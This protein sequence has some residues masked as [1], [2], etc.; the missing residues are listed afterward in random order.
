MTAI[1]VGCCTPVR[2]IDNLQKFSKIFHHSTII[3]N[4]KWD[5]EELDS[6]IQRD[7]TDAVTIENAIQDQ[8][9]T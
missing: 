3:Q 1:Y 7:R 9:Q 6:A 4:G 2:T 8:V 5:M